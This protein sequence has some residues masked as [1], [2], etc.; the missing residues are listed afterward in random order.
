NNFLSNKVRKTMKSVNSLTPSKNRI[1]LPLRREWLLIALAALAL[2]A[3]CL[4]WT[5]GRGASSSLTAYDLAEWSS[6]V[7]G[8]RYG[9][10]PMVLPGLLRAQLIFMAAIVALL[11]ARR[12]T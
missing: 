6:L 1:R 5:M 9:A 8:V 2:I 12:G 4:P 3:Y 10:Q 11:P 7:P